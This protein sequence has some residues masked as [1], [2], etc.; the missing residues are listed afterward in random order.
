MQQSYQDVMAIAVRYGKPTYF[1]TIT[2]NIQ[3]HEIQED[4]YDGQMASSLTMALLFFESERTPNMDYGKI[5]PVDWH[6]NDHI[7]FDKY[8]FLKES[9][10]KIIRMLAPLLNESQYELWTTS[11]TNQKLITLRHLGTNSFQ[12]LIGD[13][14]GLS[15]KKVSNVVT[16]VVH[17]SNHPM[18]L[19][20][21]VQFRHESSRWCVR[22]AEEFTY[23]SV[24]SRKCI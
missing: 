15:Q 13:V 8:R 18:I 7:F 6:E 17:A 22:W 10:K 5:H 14:F 4:L 24:F 1:L 2:C 12:L 9:V 23:Q 21:F 20:R 11:K 3:W 19:E 16:H